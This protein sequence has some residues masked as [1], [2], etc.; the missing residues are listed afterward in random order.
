MI[1]VGILILLGLALFHWAY[2]SAIA[3][4][5]RLGIRY[6]LFA[7]RDDLR[8]FA[9]A[10][11]VQLDHAA[12]EILEDAVNG[13]TL[14]MAEI[15]F[16]FFYSFQLRYKA[17][18]SFR[19]RIERRRQL[20]EGYQDPDFS[21]MRRRYA[22]IFREINVANSGGWMIY[23]IPVVYVAICWEW[24]RRL[25]IKLSLVPSKEFQTLSRDIGEVYVEPA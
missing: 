6:K 8:N 4:S 23:L 21:A 14:H 18:E 1:E 3:P 2:E 5:W 19:N 24:L 7:L 12:I 11:G 22:H 25:S 13:V 10:K 16:G 9:S 20:I 15:N 17:D